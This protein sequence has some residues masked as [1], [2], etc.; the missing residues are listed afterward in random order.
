[1]RKR[2]LAAAFALALAGVLAVA[3]PA[4]AHPVLNISAN[5]TTV[6]AGSTTTI[7]ITG[8]PATP[9]CTEI[10]NRYKLGGINL[11]NGQAFS[12]T[13]TITID[14]GT[15]AG[16]FTS[17]AQFY[18]SDNT[19]DGPR[20]G[21]LITVTVPSADLSVT[22]RSAGIETQGRFEVFYFVANDGPSTVPAGQA[23]ILVTVSQTAPILT[24]QSM[25]GANIV[26]DEN[27]IS[28]TGFDCDNLYDFA[29]RG[30]S[31]SALWSIGLLSI[32]QFTVT[33]TISSTVGDP[34]PANN[35]FTL[36]CNVLTPLVVTC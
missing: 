32:G 33:V 36:T 23:N 2:T 20:T 30:I 11:T 22:L 16:T 18:K 15:A 13:L 24:P 14:A 35:S 17:K 34:N 9:T 12:Y 31:L 10:I 1:M 28:G 21:P 3:A 26:F 27:C 7:T 8:T 29:V 25:G 5:P 4:F 6:V 19:T